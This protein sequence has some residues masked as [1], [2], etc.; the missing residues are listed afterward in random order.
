MTGH[1]AN[2]PYADLPNGWYCTATSPCGYGVYMKKVRSDQISAGKAGFLFLGGSTTTY[3]VIFNGFMGGWIVDVDRKEGN[4]MF[5]GQAFT[6]PLAAM[7]AAE[8][9]ILTGSSV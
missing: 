7:I 8:V 9:E 2:I 6:D 5:G 3:R 4:Y 1:T